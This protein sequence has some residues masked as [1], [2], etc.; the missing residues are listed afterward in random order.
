MGG[1]VLISILG[2]LIIYIK[3]KTPNFNKSIGKLIFKYFKTET[4]FYS[5]KNEILI[6][7]S[8][9]NQKDIDDF[10]YEA[11]KLGNQY[12]FLDK[13]SDDLEYGLLCVKYNNGNDLINKKIRG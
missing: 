8:K 3:L 1:I 2:L 7:L 12:Y 11:M 6:P 10:L 13:N 4:I 5:E 9:Y